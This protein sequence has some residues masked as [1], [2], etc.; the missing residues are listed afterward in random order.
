MNCKTLHL[1]IITLNIDAY[2]CHA[3]PNLDAFRLCNLHTAPISGGDLFERSLMQEYEQHLIGIGVKPGSKKEQHFHPY[4]KNKKGRVDVNWLHKRFITNPCRL[5]NIW[6]SNPSFN[7]HHKVVAEED[8]VV[9]EVMAAEAAQV[10]TSS[11]NLLN[12]TQYQV[13]PSHDPGLELTILSGDPLHCVFPVSPPEGEKTLSVLTLPEREK[14][15]CVQSPQEGEKTLCVQFPPGERLRVYS[16]HQKGRKLGVYSLR[17][18]PTK[19]SSKMYL[20]RKK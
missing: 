11:S 6:C 18:Y 15:L 10:V 19:F 20:S 2:L 8:M 1:V 13:L 12:D 3:H 9:A 4:K 16:P 7:L 14:T 17:I 5:H